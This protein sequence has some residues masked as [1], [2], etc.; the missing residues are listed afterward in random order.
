MNLTET[1]SKLSVLNRDDGQIFTDTS[2]LDA[3]H[4]A[5]EGSRY[6]RINQGGLFHLYSSRHISQINEPV[7]IISS[8]VDCAENITRCY[9]KLLANGLM[10]GTYDNSI[11]NSA[12]L[13]LMLE[14]KIPDNVLTAFTG[15]EECDSCGADALMEF[16]QGRLDIRHVVVLD[17]TDMGWNREADFT[18]ENNFWHAELGRTIIASAQTS[19][20]K[21]CFV[22][23]DEEDIPAYVN[24]KYVIPIEAEADESWEYD[25]YDV[26]CFSLCLPVLG[27]MHSN[28]GVYAR[29]KSFE[30]YTD[31]LEKIANL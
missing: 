25:E 9:S 27:E 5:L 4:H 15:D 30:R 14:N 19:G 24:S 29:Q 20:Y 26:E 21:W 6:F 16:A 17:V 1:L 31:M 10:K 22:P 13:Y 3:I 23:S 18:I 2:R 28:E 8:H 7:V 12:L 11:T